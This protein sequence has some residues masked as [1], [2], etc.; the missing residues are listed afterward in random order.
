LKS[1]QRSIGSDF[2]APGLIFDENGESSRSGRMGVPKTRVVEAVR[3]ERAGEL[4]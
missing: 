1:R 4:S 3:E 2:R